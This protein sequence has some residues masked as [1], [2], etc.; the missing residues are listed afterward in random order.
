M[1]SS[2]EENQVPLGFVKSA[3]T[4]RSHH[5]YLGSAGDSPLSPSEAF[6]SSTETIILMRLIKMKS[7]VKR[8]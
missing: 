6:S 3:L 7:L 1:S 2:E 4:G 5:L 8:Q